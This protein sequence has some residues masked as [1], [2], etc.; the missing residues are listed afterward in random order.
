MKK[1]LLAALFLTGC[2]PTLVQTARTV[3]EGNFQGAI[4]PGF[5]MVSADGVTGGVPVVNFAGRYGVS[6]KVDV[7]VRI[8]SVGYALQGKFALTDPTDAAKTQISIVPEVSAIAAGGAFL[9]RANVG[10]LF[11]IPVGESELTIGALTSNTIGGAGGAGGGAGG[12]VSQ[13][14]GSVGY[15]AKLGAV[16]LMPEVGFKPLVIGG[17]TASGAGS[18]GGVAFVPNVSFAL[19]IL[20]GG[21]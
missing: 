5:T 7:G 3:G 18:S 8:G 13:V 6:E 19:G 17:G 10:A 11:G 1:M 16:R 14:G 15:A 20:V 2:A 9:A 4:E 21:R 12:F